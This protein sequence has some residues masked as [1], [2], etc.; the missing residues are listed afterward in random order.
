MVDIKSEL[1]KKILES[2]QRATS[3]SDRLNQLDQ[4]NQGT[5]VPQIS[6]QGPKGYNPMNSLQALF[7][8]I[9]GRKSVSQDVESERN[10]GLDLLTKLSDYESSSKV[11]PL[12]L[13]E[14]QI[15][16]K[17]AGMKFDPESMS[18]DTDTSVSNEKQQ[19][20]NDID[21]V[22]GRDIGAMTGLPNLFKIGQNIT[23]KAKVEQIKSKLGLEARKKLK[24]SGQIS[25]YEMKIL[26]K[27]VG[28]LNYRMKDADFK[29]ELEKIRGVLSGEYKGMEE[30]SSL[31][32][33]YW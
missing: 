18:L 31:V 29:A 8:M 3:L 27:S 13:L 11:D 20:I 5:A 30:Y 4:F 24:G 7:Q 12:K 32:D 22:M 23:T 25:D 33:K 2:N 6:S 15:K 21:E 14:L 28:A 19:L 26:E 17:E 10:T 16:A 1:E 9:S